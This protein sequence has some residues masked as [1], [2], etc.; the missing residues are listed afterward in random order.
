MKQGGFFLLF[1]SIFGTLWEKHLQNKNIPQC[2]VRICALLNWEGAE[3][4]ACPKTWEV[5]MLKLKAST[6]PDSP[7][8]LT[9]ISPGTVRVA[10]E[11]VSFVDWSGPQISSP[12][13]MS[14]LFLRGVCITYHFLYI[15]SLHTRFW[16]ECR[17]LLSY[18][19]KRP[20]KESSATLS[21]YELLRES[22][23]N[24]CTDDS[25]TPA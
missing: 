6:D 9:P 16:K 12:C 8:P 5:G 22:Y 18:I 23:F 7:L 25:I 17:S 2:S 24:R 13:K 4:R 1:S 14:R 20:M 15:A 10:D 11:L 21:P 3:V 19:P